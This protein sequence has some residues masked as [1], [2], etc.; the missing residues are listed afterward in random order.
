M[1]YDGERTYCCGA[2]T[3]GEGP[4]PDLDGYGKCFESQTSLRVS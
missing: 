4:N 1:R 2:L 3:A